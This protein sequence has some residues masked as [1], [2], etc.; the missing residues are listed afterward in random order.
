MLLGVLP[1]LL[2]KEDWGKAKAIVIF[3]GS[4]DASFPETNPEQVAP[5]TQGST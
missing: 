1:D 3:L 4:N 5:P 2:S